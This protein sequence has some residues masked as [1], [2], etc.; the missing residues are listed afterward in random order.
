MIITA[1]NSEDLRDLGSYLVDTD[2]LRGCVRERSRPPGPEDMGPVLEALEIL[3]GPGGVTA[4]TATAVIAW[5]RSRRSSVRI[6][7]RGAENRVLEVEA[8]KVSGLDAAGLEQLTE[9]LL[10]TV[11]PRERDWPPTGE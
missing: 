9:T 6:T 2:E 1:D 10:R 4:A 11:D 7:V 3:V 5:V 8:N